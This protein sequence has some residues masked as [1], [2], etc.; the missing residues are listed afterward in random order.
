[1]ATI[2]GSWEHGLLVKGEIIAGVME[3]DVLRRGKSAKA[4]GILNL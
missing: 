3:K 4:E 2:L 1:M